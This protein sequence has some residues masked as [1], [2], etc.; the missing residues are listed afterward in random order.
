[1]EPA[2]RPRGAKSKHK[3]RIRKAVES[4]DYEETI[5][6]LDQSEGPRKSLWAVVELRDAAF[7]RYQGFVDRQ[8]QAQRNPRKSPV[9]WY[10]LSQELSFR[11]MFTDFNK[12]LSVL[13]KYPI[14][15]LMEAFEEIKEE[16]EE[17]V[18]FDKDRHKAK[19]V[20][21]CC[22]ESYK[23]ILDMLARLAAVVAG[24]P[25]WSS[26]LPENY[27][28]SVLDG[29]YSPL[30][31][32]SKERF[33]RNAFTH[34][35]AV[36]MK[37]NRFILEDKK[38]NKKRLS[39]SHLDKEVRTVTLRLVLVTEGMA[40]P[41]SVAYEIAGTIMKLQKGETADKLESNS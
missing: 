17:V 34:S 6:L 1:M 2:K 13:E 21:L 24:D 36:P 27:L 16:A 23:K 12:Y 40:L 35:G 9:A 33:I 30:V 4:G 41:T 19:H 3:E 37:G 29:R 39:L 14:R 26:T 25:K 20:L 5:R 7:R 15:N 10:E 38:G 32:D 11:A 8:T 18:S 28:E 22:Y 31:P